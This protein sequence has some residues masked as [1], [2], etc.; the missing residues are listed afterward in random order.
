[1]RRRTHYLAC[2]RLNQH[3]FEHYEISNFALPWLPLGGTQTANTG[4][5][6]NTRSRPAPTR[7]FDGAGCVPARLRRLTD[8]IAAVRNEEEVPDFERQNQ[9]P[10]ASTLRTSDG[11]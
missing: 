11:V 4:I 7:L 8:G 6:P 1:M 5:F 2:A 10:Y 9:Y 3:G